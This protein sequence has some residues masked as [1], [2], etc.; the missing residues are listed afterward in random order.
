MKQRAARGFVLPAIVL[1]LA[2]GALLVVDAVRGA[3]LTQA[4]AGAARQRLRAF[5]AA[6][7]GVAAAQ[8]ALAALRDPPAITEAAPAAGV[9]STTRV[10][11]ELIETMTAG[12]SANRVLAQRFRVQSTGRAAR[13]AQV[14]VEAGFTRRIAAP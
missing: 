8:G 3:T 11:L 6:E 14:S 4:L 9:T 5:D 10:R 2:L 7:S 12:Y 1:L 13:G